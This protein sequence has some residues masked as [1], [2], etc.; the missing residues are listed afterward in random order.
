MGPMSDPAAA[1]PLV[2]AYALGPFATNCYL[3]HVPP[4][5]DCWIV[6]VSFN[7][8]PMLDR[9][10]DTGLNPIAIILTH[11]H[12]DHI[13]GL[14]EARAMFPGVPV[15]IHQ[16]EATHLADPMLNLSGAYGFPITAQPADEL[17]KGGETLE[18]SGSKWRVHWTPGHS[19]GGITLSCDAARIAL[20]GDTLFAGSIGRS[21]FPTS[22][23]KDLIKSIQSVLYTLP[24]DTQVYAGH[25]P[26][27]T[28]GHEKATNPYVRA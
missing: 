26:P 18:L 8:G 3:V 20:V 7:P 19:P 9:V 6:D 28:I 22:N 16:A 21:D 1:N 23:E 12:V 4:S 11:A 14:N 5:P 25:G 17:L 27:T 15:L 2:E 24:D 13:A 10:R